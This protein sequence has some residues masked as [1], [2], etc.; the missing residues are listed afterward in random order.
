MKN[1]ARLSPYKPVDDKEWILL[2]P[3]CRHTGQSR[4][5]EGVYKT[6]PEVGI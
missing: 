2:T 1:G 6:R 4:K 5:K 3:H